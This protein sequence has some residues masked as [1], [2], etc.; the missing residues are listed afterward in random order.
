MAIARPSAFAALL[1]RY[2]TAAGL[3]QEELAER[4]R[5]SVRGISDLERGVNLTPR[6]DTVEQLAAALALPAP[7]RSRFEAAARGLRVGAP[8]HR[9]AGSFQPE[10]NVPAPAFVGRAHELSLLERHIAG[11]GPPVLM[12]A[13]EPGIGKTRLLQEVARRAT[14]NG[15]TVLQGGCQRR[16]G[17]EPYAPLLDALAAYISCLSGPQLRA[18]LQGCS[19]L[20][21]LVP[22]L[23]E[24]VSAPFPLGTL[25]PEQERRLVFGAATRFLTNVAG[26]AGVLLA[27]DDLQWAGIDA[28]DLLAA[29][30]RSAPEVSLRLVGTYRDT[31]V[32]SKDPLSITLAD[33]AQ[34]GLVRQLTLGPLQTQEAAQLLDGLLAGAER[35]GAEVIERILQ[36]A[37]GVPFFLVSCAHGLRTGAFQ[38]GTGALPGRDLPWD[39]AQGVRQRVAGLPE[40]AQEVLGAA[41]VTGRRAHRALLVAV[42]GLA[43]EAVIT[44]LES[45]FRARL[46]AEEGEDAYRFPH[47]MIREVVEADLSAARRTVLHRRIALTLEQEPSEASVELLAYHYS[48]SGE[49]AKAILYLEQA[50]DKARAQHANAAAAVHYGELVHM[51]E[52]LGRTKESACAREKL[53]SVLAT[54]ARYDEALEILDR[55]VET[56]RSIGDLEAVARVTAE[57]GFSVHGP[58]GTPQ[59]GINRIQPLV[60]RLSVGNAS[61][62][63]AALYAALSQLS[64]R[65]GRYREALAAAEPLAELGRALGD[66]RIL[67][68][69]EVGR[70]SN[71]IMLGQLQEARAAL[72]AAIPLAETASDLISLAHAVN[73]TAATY[74]LGGEFDQ[75]GVYYRRAI[76]VGE[77]MGDPAW[78]AFAMANLGKLLWLLGEWDHARTH[79]EQALGIIRSLGPS[80]YS[81]YPPLYLGQLCLAEGEW[82]QASGYLEESIPIARRSGDLRAQRIG[83]ALLAERD[84]LEGHPSAVLAR[85][86]PLLDR[87]GLEE[88][89]VT[90]LLPLLAWAHLELGADQP[91]E[92]I[93]AKA[94]DRADRHHCRV[95]LVDALRVHA[96]VLTRSGHWEEAQ[97][98]LESAASLARSMPYPYAEARALSEYGMLHAKKGEPQRARERLEEAL[99]VFRRLGARPYITRMEQTLM[100][101]A[102]A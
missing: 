56:Y 67:A 17:Q 5:L 55:A 80:W 94:V 47:D 64:F 79:L 11:E 43:E 35:T 12:L 28:L 65:S 40:A 74:M 72:E 24:M 76:D 15:M 14:I 83:Q 45:T 51:L 4:A 19:W 1:K 95:Y 44:A 62:V 13:G 96:M 9:Q 7:D 20:V 41:A 32:E 102:T 3:T 16:S 70:G 2:R 63:L 30:V 88:Q 90:G 60:E 22:E 34:G 21:R 31:E 61:P 52:E 78:A 71:L 92:E 73:N 75:A 37:G 77:Q 42:T 81:A 36:R 84:L 8:L 82:E 26:S 39:L 23:V 18:A 46:L 97:S 66:A 48:R 91:A 27:L 6:K 87:P 86:E 98:S 89:D 29:L 59:E 101:S 50:G 69:A 85:L 10:A 54:A 100:D 53:G 38:R 68:R 49:R 33:L 93:A 58:R 25:L 99:M 57:I